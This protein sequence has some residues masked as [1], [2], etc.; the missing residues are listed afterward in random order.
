MNLLNGEVTQSTLNNVLSPNLLVDPIKEPEKFQTFMITRALN[1][2]L[3][4]TSNSLF[5][6][7]REY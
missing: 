5:K 2:S 3:Q 4:N 6:D 1:K 7:K